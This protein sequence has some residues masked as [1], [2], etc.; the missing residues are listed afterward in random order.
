MMGFLKKLVLP[1]ILVSLALLE[2][3]CSAPSRTADSFN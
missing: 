3:I 1:F 2:G